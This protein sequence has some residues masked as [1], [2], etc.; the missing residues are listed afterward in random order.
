MNNL[1]LNIIENKEF[2]ILI[3]SLF[4]LVVP[5]WQFLYNKSK[6]LRQI[7]LINFHEK[8]IS[9]ISNLGDIKAGLDEQVA[10][11][12]E[13]R[14]FPKYYP[15]ILRILSSNKDRWQNMLRNEPQ[16]KILIDEA[17]ET[18]NYIK[19]KVKNS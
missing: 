2:F 10:V 16:F 9:K 8:M 15:V 14:N 11:I 18:I 1:I 5:V 3:M 7:N 12:F 13:L 17:D 6:E 19:K 4:G